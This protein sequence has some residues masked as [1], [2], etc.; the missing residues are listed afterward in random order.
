MSAALPASPSPQDN[1]AA[2]DLAKRLVE[3]LRQMDAGK[4]APPLPLPPESGR[5]E[6]ATTEE[7]A[8]KLAAE[9]KTEG[10]GPDAPS[11]KSGEASLDSPSLSSLPASQEANSISQE[12]VE[13]ALEGKEDGRRVD[14]DLGRRGLPSAVKTAIVSQIACFQSLT[15]VRDYVK[16][17]FGLEVPLSQLTAYDPTRPGGRLGKRLRLL[18]DEARANYIARSADVAIAHQAHR[19]RLI[20]EVV[21]KAGKSKDYNAALKGLELAAKEM[22]GLMD[23]SVARKVEHT[24]VIGHAHLN[25]DDARQEVAMRLR[26]MVEKMPVV[27]ALPAPEDAEFSA[28]PDSTG[29]PTP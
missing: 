3:R 9:T 10:R 14:P 18:F 21:E 22:G 19:L 27:E 13:R 4:A 11:H 23:A 20:G 16:L 29:T 7:K 28:I 5:P 26:D 1:D 17:E 15:S 6:G 2:T 24:G 25:V 8:P 12:M